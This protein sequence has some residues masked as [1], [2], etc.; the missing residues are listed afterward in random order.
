MACS[1]H[2]HDAVPDPEIFV[3]RGTD[4]SSVT[5]TTSWYDAE[6]SLE[7]IAPQRREVDD[8]TFD[9]DLYREGRIQ[10]IGN[11]TLLPKE[12]NQTLSNMSWEKKR[13]YFE[14][15]SNRDPEERRKLINRYN[16]HQKTKQLLDNDFVPFCADL[17]QF[18]DECWK[19]CDVAQRGE[20]LAGLMWD[21]FA[22][23]LGL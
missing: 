8:N 15:F 13:K 18:V 17:A 4:G 1:V 20:R 21:R 3:R 2:N 14:V 12:E 16:L 19:T 10:R 23:S 9:N 7:H 5:L 22:P 11:L 6:L